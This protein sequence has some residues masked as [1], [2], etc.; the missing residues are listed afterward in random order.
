M[1]NDKKIAIIGTGISGLTCGYYL[2]KKG[3]QVTMYEAAG[4]I[5]GHTHTVT[6][7]YMGE[8]ARV[9]TGFIVFNDRTYP[10]FI[11]LMEEIGVTSQPTEMSFSVRNDQAGMEYSGSSFSGLFAQRSNLVRPSFLRMLRDILRFNK[12]V[13]VHAQTDPHMTIGAYLDRSGYTQAFTENYL[14][15]MIAAI[16]SMGTDDCRDFPLA[17]FVKFFSNHG[18]LDLTD[19]PQWYTIHG[20][21]SSYVEPLTRSYHQGIM[22]NKPVRQVRRRLD[23]VE[24][25]TDSGIDHYDQVVLAC[26]GDDALSLLEEPTEDESRVL[27]NFQFSRNRVVLHADESHLPGKKR[28]WASWNYRVTEGGEGASTLTYNMNILQRL[29]TNHTYLVTLN[30]EVDPAHVIRE[31][32]YSHPVYTVSMIDAQSQWHRISGVNRIHY[33]GAYWLNGFH[34][35]GVNSGLR[36]SKMLGGE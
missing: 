19:R 16:W 14:M 10:N 6:T 1:T 18:L 23:G 31:F 11:K 3:F 8:H 17:F 4:Y 7:E 36:V 33:C 25:A 5:G 21:S 9:D 2:T 32:D 28:A 27:S 29:K 30:Q 26:H 13:R 12:E 22:L 34:E 20:G 15:P 35:D 24:V